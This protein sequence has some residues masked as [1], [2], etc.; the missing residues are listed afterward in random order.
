MSAYL[1]VIKVPVDEK[2]KKKTSSKSDSTNK[3]DSEKNTNTQ[4]NSKDKTGNEN[5]LSE[6]KDAV[7]NISKD[8]DVD[9]RSKD[10]N[11]LEE[12][13]EII[14]VEKDENAVE[15][16][17][18]SSSDVNEGLCDLEQKTKAQETRTA[19]GNVDESLNDTPREAG[20]NGNTKEGQKLDQNILNKAVKEV[21][22]AE[23]THVVDEKT[24]QEN[25]IADTEK[26]NGKV[27]DEKKEVSDEN[28]VNSQEKKESESA[29]T[30]NVKEN[31]VVDVTEKE[32]N[33]DSK[34]EQIEETNEKGQVSFLD[35]P[36][37][38][39]S[40]K[41][42]LQFFSID[43]VIATKTDNGKCWQIV[44]VD[45]G[46]ERCEKVLN[47]LAE[48]RI[49]DIPSSSICIFPASI[50]RGAQPQE[51]AEDDED[52]NASDDGDKEMEGKFK[53][54]IRARMLV[55]QV[56]N[57]V[58]ENAEFT[59]DYVLLIILASI[60]AGLGLAESSSVVLVASML[61]SPLMGPILALT[62]GAV[63]QNVSLRSLGLRNETIGLLLCIVS[64]RQFT[65]IKHSHDI[66]HV[67][68]NLGKKL[69]AKHSRIGNFHTHILMYAAKRFAYTPPVYKA[70]S[71]LAAIDYNEHIE[72]PAALTKEGKK[73]YHRTFNKKSERWSAVEVKVKKTYAY[74]KNLLHNI[75]CMRLRDRVGMNRRME[76]APDDPRRLLS[77]L[78]SV[79]P[80]PTSELVTE[81]LSRF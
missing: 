46:G 55:T 43:N 79:E 14:Q 78:A 45:E 52:D 1:F 42:V 18:D 26:Q 32:T 57:S 28:D 80:K 37:P 24:L 76:L 77:H 54:S 73:I 72:R 16:Q 38:I 65:H 68:K 30:E 36:P 33:E 34:E 58:K 53:K 66:W 64:E 44:F 11:L 5:Q 35:I 31:E 59:F 6:N 63:I 13:N 81:K 8:S 27:I 9:L 3:N 50:Y 39:E 49:G 48:Y 74:I 4:E 22:C 40:V 17:N 2:E 60:I 25:V 71:Q 61:V 62:F 21:D 70:R 47:K 19:E 69:V 12:S 20:I 56:V 15:N 10:D 67:A 75:F 41:E 7:M 29:I 51:T 23:T